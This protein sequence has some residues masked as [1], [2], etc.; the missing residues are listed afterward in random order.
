MSTHPTTLSA[1][2][3]A[4]FHDEGFVV[5]RGAFSPDDAAATR[6][7]WWA[8][9]AE[10]HGVREHDRATWRQP[11]ADLKAAKFAPIGARLAS[12]R[13]RGVI[14]DLVGAGAW[15]E[16]KHWGRV[17]TTFPETRGAWDVPT[18][19]WHSDNPCAWHR[20]AMNG[21]MLFSFIGEVRPRSGGTLIIAGSPRLLQ[22]LDRE[23]TRGGRKDDAAGNRDAFYR[24]HPWLKAL[25]GHAASPA[26]RIAAFMDDGA[27]IEGVRLRV[28]ELTGAPGD[29]VFCHP[30]IAHSAAPNHG[31]APRFMRIA[32]VLA[33]QALDYRSGRATPP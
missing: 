22:R 24:S 27:E 26:D 8:E 13:V 3:I 6:R 18:K 5:V 17:L 4:Q 15:P 23:L 31:E 28:V 21:V 33:R 25:A 11:R 19:L 16:P 9:L 30:I 10:V 32:G 7:E 29:M 12:P 20:T 1:A 14:D 2:E